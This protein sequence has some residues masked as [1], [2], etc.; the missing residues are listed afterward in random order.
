MTKNLQSA[1]P[2]AAMFVATMLCVAGISSHAASPF[3]PAK[4]SIGNKDW[5]TDGKGNAKP[6]IGNKDWTTD[7]NG[8]AKPSIGNKEWTT[9]GRGN[10]KPAIGNK[11]WQ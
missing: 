10:P 9:D 8:K 2:L 5:T 6:A 1:T 4:P 11:G 7:A 3:D